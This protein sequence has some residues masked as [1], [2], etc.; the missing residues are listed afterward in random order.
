MEKGLKKRHVAATKMNAESSRSHAV[1][2]IVLTE[3]RVTGK[4]TGEKVSKISLVDL[5]GSER[6]AK[7]GA[8][9]ARLKEGANINKSLTVLGQVISGLAEQAGKKGKKKGIV[10]Y[11]DSVL[12]WLL[13]NNLGG[14]SRTIMAA[15]I[16]PAGDNYA[17]TMSTL[18]Y[19]DSAKKIVNDAVVN[20]DPNARMIRELKEEVARLKSQVG[21]AGGGGGGGGDAPAE[22]VEALQLKKKLEESERLMGEISQSWEDKL[23]Q[24]ESLL[25]QQE[26]LFKEHSATISG[27]DGALRLSSDRPSFISLRSGDVAIFSLSAPRSVL[28]AEMQD[29]PEGYIAI[30]PAGETGV[31]A[32]M[33]T[34]E[35]EAG[36][37]FDKVVLTS[38]QSEHVY[39]NGSA[40]TPGEPFALT[41]SCVVQLGH[42]LTLQFTNPSEASWMKVQGISTKQFSFADEQKRAEQIAAEKAQLV[43]EKKTLAAENEAKRREAMAALSDAEGKA[44]SEAERRAQADRENL[45]LKERLAKMEELIKAEQEARAKEAEAAQRAEAIRQEEEDKIT[46]AEMELEKRVAEA[47]ENGEVF[48]DAELICAT[49]EVQKAAAEKIALVEQE[50]AAQAQASSAVSAQ[51][52]HLEAAVSVDMD[53]IEVSAR[54]QRHWKQALRAIIE[55]KTGRQSF[56]SIVWKASRQNKADADTFARLRTQR[57]LAAPLDMAVPQEASLG[58]AAGEAA[59]VEEDEADTEMVGVEQFMAF[60]ETD[61]PAQPTAVAL[62]KLAKVPNPADVPKR[63]QRL[64][65]VR[66]TDAMIMDLRPLLVLSHITTLDL[67]SN[68]IQDLALFPVLPALMSLSLKKNVMRSIGYEGGSGKAKMNRLGVLDLNDNKELASIDGI[69]DLAPKLEVLKVKRTNLFAKGALQPL[70]A[71][72]ETL[73]SVDLTGLPGADVSVFKMMPNVEVI[74]PG[75]KSA[76]DAMHVGTKNVQAGAAKLSQAANKAGD[77][78]AGALGKLGKMTWGKKKGKK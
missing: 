68:R 76:S 27:G 41:H 59:L 72:E 30:A 1:F 54:A 32:A 49:E 63:L 34:V 4:I 78:V 53:R 64:K 11:R 25:K 16:S 33:C 45:E 62:Q 6:S 19:A 40:L 26:E 18:R 42:A 9:G 70:L 28:G 55:Q 73:V 65:N 51:V 60:W 75:I 46:E 8:K 66:I 35:V 21:A 77:A 69:Y 67:S 22:N 71:L 57:G 48:A 7:T 74:A 20:E 39:V 12:T 47:E 50:A 17:E 2:T 37:E 44:A 43:A 5:A 23:Q 56:F 3:V 36:D 24:S 13:K 10:P 38:A 61:G 52:N 29:A 58:G 15:A 31:D 14:N